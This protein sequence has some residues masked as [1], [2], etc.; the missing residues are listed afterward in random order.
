MPSA[1]FPLEASFLVPRLALALA[2]GFVVPAAVRAALDEP[3]IHEH[4]A[5][6]AAA[7][8]ARWLALPAGLWGASSVPMPAGWVALALFAPFAAF[9]ALC[10]LLSVAGH[11]SA[12]ASASAE[13]G[14][15]AALASTALAAGWGGA[16]AAGLALLG[17]GGD[18]ALGLTAQIATGIVGPLGIAAALTRWLPRDESPRAKAT[19][20]AHGVATFGLTASVG[21]LAGAL[22]LAP[23]RATWA[24]G[25]AA[26]STGLVAILLAELAS[27]VR[28]S[29]GVKVALGSAALT[30]LAWVVLPFA[31]RERLLASG[32]LFAL[33]AA[34]GLLVFL[35]GSFAGLR[36]MRRARPSASLTS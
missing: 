2:L 1:P 16:H 11:S 27:R 22:R 3:A 15:R 7:R 36:R 8:W 5:R 35:L 23:A 30:G 24:L 26:V 6:A 9:G 32:T 10:A 31:W 19:R 33:H 14:S 17:Q 13:V 29:L 21:W 34:A 25:L 4:G 20:A 28:T 18:D 12:H